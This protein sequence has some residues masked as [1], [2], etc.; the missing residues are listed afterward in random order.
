MKFLRS[1]AT[2]IA[3]L[4]GIAGIAIKVYAVL[5]TLPSTTGNLIR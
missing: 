2:F 1:P 4:I 5:L 3:A